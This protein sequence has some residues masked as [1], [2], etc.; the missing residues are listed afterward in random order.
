MRGLKFAGVVGLFLVVNVTAMGSVSAA[1]DMPEVLRYA[2]KYSQ[3]QPDVMN[4]NALPD[5]Q[6]GLSRKLARS[7]LIRRQQQTR[8]QALEAR[9]KALQTRTDDGQQEKVRNEA[10]SRDLAASERQRETLV[11]QVSDLQ[12]Q[13][14]T[15]GQLLQN[16]LAAKG[17][18]LAAK[19][20]ELAAAK[21]VAEKLK[22][23]KTGLENALKTLQQ[24]MRAPVDLKTLPQKQA[25]AAGVMYAK[26]VREAK[27]GNQM[28]G[29]SLDSAA[30]VAGLT[31][32][33]DDRPLKL[34]A[35]E[36]ARV[37][38]S[39]EQ[40]TSEGF[41]TVTAAQARQAEVWL[42]KFRKGKG[43]TRD[44]A[45]FWYQVTYEGDGGLL[46]P[47]DI[48][49]VVVEEQL[50][51]GTVV[52]DMDR[53]G[54]SLRQK[55]ADFPPVFAAGLMRLKNHGQITLVVPPELAYGDKG[56]PPDIPPGATMIY[57]M[58][59]SDRIPAETART[60]PVLI[61]DGQQKKTDGR[62]MP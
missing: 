26:D 42:K 18:E 19:G 60:S 33:L 8:L 24:K 25:Y 30:L 16:T 28:L 51:D 40:A 45:G 36:L 49:D 38:T 50:T 54:N 20:D 5:H 29:V 7:E 61:P 13:I 43:V 47:E 39:L 46:T 21:K 1:D 4:R 2:S 56:Y 34:D 9:I 6:V 22:S 62:S 14:K 44:E 41:R 27:A 35:K 37:T 11:K 12:A 55:V 3:G 10:L 23:E 57:R 17:D 31:D 53:A 59:V 48:V 52:S 15:A 58:R 32:A